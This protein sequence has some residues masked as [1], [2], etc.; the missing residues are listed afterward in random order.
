MFT[1]KTE[2]LITYLA[3]IRFHNL[4]FS[5]KFFAQQGLS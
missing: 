5:T 2:A 1:S 3:D 4:L